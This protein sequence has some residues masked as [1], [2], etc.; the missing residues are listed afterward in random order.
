MWVR[1]VWREP[2]HL[3]IS[4]GS[5]HWPAVLPIYSYT[6]V[7]WKFVEKD[8][9]VLPSKLSVIIKFYL[10][11]RMFFLLVFIII[12]VKWG[13]SKELLTRYLQ[14]NTFN[15]RF[16]SNSYFLLFLAIFWSPLHL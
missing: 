14:M 12:F 5:A 10:I 11:V 7:R 1:E 3:I 16:Q 9:G 15:S 2:R 8:D 13:Q 4:V 6:R